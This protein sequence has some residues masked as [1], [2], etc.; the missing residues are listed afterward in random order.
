MSSSYSYYSQA[1]EVV[2][3]RDGKLDSLPCERIRFDYPEQ[4]GRSEV[5]MGR[6]PNGDIYA[7]VI[8]TQ[9]AGGEPSK[10]S[11]RLFRSVDGGLTWTSQP[12]SMPGGYGLVAF[13]VL[14]DG[15]LLAAGGGGAGYQPRIDISINRSTDQ[16]KNWKRIGVIS[17]DPYERIGEGFLRLTQL[18]DGT[19]LF[20]VHRSSS[21]PEG[22]G[23]VPNAWPD[24]HSAHHVFRSTDAGVTWQGG[25]PNG[26]M[27]TTCGEGP[28]ATYTGLGGTFPG[29]CEAHV[30]ELEKGNLLAAFRY[31]GPPLDWHASM[32]ERWGGLKADG[33]GRLFKHVFLG[34]SEDA[35]R[36][37]KDLRPLLDIKGKPLLVLGQ[38]H[39]QLVKLPDNRVVLVHD[40]RYPTERCDTTGRISEDSGRTWSREAYHLLAGSGYAASVALEDG[41][42][43]TVAGATRWDESGQPIP[44]EP[45]NTQAI[46]WKP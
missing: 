36:T 20:P 16:G 40:N 13:T 21:A 10:P 26:K 18:S 42:I 27:V 46:R 32:A 38:C 30:I 29:C 5:C 39:G 23:Q 37:W 9:G 41:T 11:Q 24:Q 2:I 4:D 28:D 19:I 1:D 14:N 45:W 3:E 31:S 8:A 43:V 15:T 44:G 7:A 6:A 22:E 17:A 33:G 12:V 35:G 34:D 25:D